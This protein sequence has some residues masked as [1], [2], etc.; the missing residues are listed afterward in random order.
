MSKTEDNDLA[1]VELKKATLRFG[2]RTLWHEI[3]ARVDPGEF[4]AILGPNGT[5]KSTLLKAILGL[6]PLTSG[7]IRVFGKE[8]GEDNAVIGL[9]PQQKSFDRSLPIR[10]RD[11]VELGLNG[12]Q[13][14]WH[15]HSQA[16]QQV[17]EAIA[18][19]QASG[20]A[21]GPIGLLSGGEQQRLRIAQALISKPKLLLCDEPLLSLDLSSQRTVTNVL[22]DYRKQTNAAVIFVTHEINPVL[23]FVDRVL[24]IANGKWVIDKPD[25]V[26]RTEVLSSLYGSPVDVISHNGRLIVIGADEAAHTTE[27]AHHEDHA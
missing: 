9:V 19:V 20:Y 1:A 6:A 24:Y 2:N 10:G 18:M 16:R 22:D 11:L 27:G 21:D 15:N 4:V 8:P 25:K 13:Y 12:T 23:P 17:D 3:D 7:S 26:L 14:G 5:G